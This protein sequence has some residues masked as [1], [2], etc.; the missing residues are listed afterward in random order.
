MGEASC[1]KIGDIVDEYLISS[2]QEGRHQ[3]ARMLTIAIR[4]LREVHY[5]VSGATVWRQIE[6]D[7]QNKYCLPHSVIKII[8][9]FIPT[10]QGLVPIVSNAGAKIKPLNLEPA[11]FSDEYTQQ[12]VSEYWQNGQFKGGVYSGGDGNPYTYHHNKETGNIHFSTNIPASILAQFLTDLET[13]NKDYLVHPFIADAIMQYMWYA[14]NRFKRNV[15][16]GAKAEMQR[17]Y[18]TAK[19]FAKMRIIAMPA[20]EMKAARSSSI[21]LTTK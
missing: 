1:T 12:S 7:E 2:G 20:A 9:F 6:L 13:V 16:E 5:D 11:I 3:Y 14:D 4:G 17:K 21:S 18:V 10:S 15:P 19:T 8:G